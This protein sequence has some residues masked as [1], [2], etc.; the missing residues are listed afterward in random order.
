MDEQPIINPT[1]EH[2]FRNSQEYF[3]NLAQR[4]NSV[5]QK[6]QNILNQ[7]IQNGPSS[8]KSNPE[9]QL[10]AERHEL[11]HFFVSVNLVVAHSS[12][13]S[14]E[15]VQESLSLLQKQHEL[16]EENSEV[17]RENIEI[18]KEMKAVQKRAI[19]ACVGL[20]KPNSS[21]YSQSKKMRTK[22]KP[23]CQ[24]HGLKKVKLNDD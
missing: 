20:S 24:N 7:V 23:G 21:D 11:F 14:T 8:Y 16:L 2:I 4:A 6:F 18:M 19:R 12:Q 3:S 15:L 1:E 5:I 10:L 22:A 13:L 9:Y 17:A